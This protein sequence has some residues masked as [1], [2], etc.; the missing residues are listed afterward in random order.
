MIYRVGRDF[1]VAGVS[2]NL[3]PVCDDKNTLMFVLSIKSLMVNK[4]VNVTG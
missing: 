3:A 4:D 2:A 1:F